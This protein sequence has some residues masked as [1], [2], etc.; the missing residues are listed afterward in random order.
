MDTKIIEA[1]G[2]DKALVQEQVVSNITNQM[3]PNI[4]HE[5]KM[6]VLA[7]LDKAVDNMIAEIVEEVTS[8]VFQPTTSWGEPN[9]EP[10]TI[11]DMIA[12]KTLKWWEDK[13][14]RQGKPTRYTGAITRAEYFAEKTVGEYVRR[15]LDNDIKDL[16][17]RAKETIND[18]MAEA[19][20]K[21]LKRM[22]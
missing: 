10:T 19:I 1:L 18:A 2:I 8:D 3:M 13:V 6:T 16:T 7:N 20:K 12:E 9:G 17:A 4:R 22:W 11:K 5:I 14:D 15:Q 21:N